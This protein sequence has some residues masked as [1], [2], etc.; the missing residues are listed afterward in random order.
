MSKPFVVKKLSR[1]QFLE[2]AIET[3]AIRQLSSFMKSYSRGDQ[4]VADKPTCVTCFDMSGS[5]KTTTILEASKKASCFI[6]HISL[7]NNPLFRMLF[8][9]FGLPPNGVNEVKVIFDYN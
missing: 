7:I 9:S 2:P 1:N 4:T 3:D 6:V 8:K 5:G